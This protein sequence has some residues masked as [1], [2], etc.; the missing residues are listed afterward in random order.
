[1]VDTR[2]D[3]ARRSL[4]MRRAFVI[5]LILLVGAV[6]TAPSTGAAPTQ[7]KTVTGEANGAGGFVFR[8]G[9]LIVAATSGT[10]RAAHLGRGTYTLNI[11][12]VTVDGGLLYAGVFDLLT[13]RGASLHA[14]FVTDGT[15]SGYPATV[16]SGSGRFSGA[17][18]TLVLDVEQFN[19]TNCDP[20]TGLCFNWDEHITISGTITPA[21]GAPR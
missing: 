12:A 19:R 5:A 10:Y 20:F 8:S 17:T 2:A 3:S 15:S 14:T 6:G 1:M 9:C 16:Q 18:G 21:R 4:V 7:T 11:C 13:K